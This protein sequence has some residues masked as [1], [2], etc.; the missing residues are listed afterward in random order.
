MSNK[1][2]ISVIGCGHLGSIHTKL[3]AANENA[4]L[5]GIYDIDPARAETI[6]QNFNCKSYSS[7][8]EAIAA[9][10]AVTIASP[11]SEHFQLARLA[12]LQKKHCL[13]EKP[14]TAQYSEAQEL[15]ELAANNNV[16]VQ[17]GHV[18]RFNPAIAALDSYNLKPVFIEAHRLSQFK[19][20]A[21]DVPV[22]HDLMIHDIDIVLWLVGSQVESI[23]ANGVSVLSDSIDICNAR[24]TFA[25]GAVANLTASRISARPMRKMR[26]FQQNAYISI[27][28]SIPEVEVYRLAS[29]SEEPKSNALVAQMLGSIDA[30]SKK[31]NIAYEKPDI[32]QINA[33][34]EEQ[35]AF[36]EAI[37]SGNPGTAANATEAAEALRIAEEISKMVMK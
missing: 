16:L 15:I 23:Q 13:I 27:D 8:E 32:P 17:V 9:A 25:N 33:I 7:L 36:C 10:D 12:I 1:I 26:L 20:R 2:K 18:E 28:F 14:I 30:G 6:S 3:W 4:E 11:T 35:K 19:P 22:I 34:A 21:L 24:I 37:S 29:D 5:A 31:L